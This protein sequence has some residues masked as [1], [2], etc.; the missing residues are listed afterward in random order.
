MFF[1]AIEV[2]R[3]IQTKDFQNSINAKINRGQ[4]RIN[5]IISPFKQ[6][7]NTPLAP[8]VLMELGKILEQREKKIDVIIYYEQI[9]SW[10]GTQDFKDEVERRWILAKETLAEKTNNPQPLKEAKQKRIEMGIEDV[11]IG[12]V[13]SLS[14]SLWESI[15]EF[16]MNLSMKEAKKNIKNKEVEIEDH[17][18]SMAT[19]TS[20]IP[21]ELSTK[22]RFLT[23]VIIN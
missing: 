3:K 14:R 1:Q 6:Y 13:P 8:L 11:T 15:Y 22:N 17:D 20:A 9:K 5:G 12:N 23:M 16:A 19:R 7:A 4:E 2:I 18:D 10:Y 21:V